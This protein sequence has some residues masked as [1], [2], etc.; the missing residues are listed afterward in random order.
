MVGADSCPGNK[1]TSYFS[2]MIEFYVEYQILPTYERFLLNT[3]FSPHELRLKVNG[4]WQYYLYYIKPI[5]KDRITLAE[6]SEIFW[7]IYKLLNRNR[8]WLSGMIK[9]YGLGVSIQFWKCWFGLTDN[10]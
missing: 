3:A 4:S 2:Q 5:F 7:I 9:I 10:I 6:N 1:K 8:R